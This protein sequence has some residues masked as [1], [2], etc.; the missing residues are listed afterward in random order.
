MTAYWRPL[1]KGNWK[2]LDIP[3]RARGVFEG[4]IPADVPGDGDFEY[5]L[6][7]RMADGAKLVWPAAVPSQPHSVIFGPAEKE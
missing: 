7:A 2:T 6:E 3:R 1:G 4:E 5:Y